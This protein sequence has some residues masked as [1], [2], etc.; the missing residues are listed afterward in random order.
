M[1][2]PVLLADMIANAPREFGE[3]HRSST[4]SRKTRRRLR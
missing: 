1:R 3:R 4:R 2:V